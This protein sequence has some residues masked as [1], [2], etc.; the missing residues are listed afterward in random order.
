M[1]LLFPVRS[2]PP[3]RVAIAVFGLMPG[4]NVR[5]EG[6]RVGKVAMV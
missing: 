2:S 3:L 4:V 5:D 1:Q 6:V